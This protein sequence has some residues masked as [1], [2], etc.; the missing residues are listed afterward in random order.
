MNILQIGEERGKKIGEAIG[1]E[2]GR[3][4]CCLSNCAIC[5]KIIFCQ[6]MG[7]TF[8]DMYNLYKK[9]NV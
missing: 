4:R 2:I 3:D 5:Q 7:L 1:K 8:F 6:I 9:L